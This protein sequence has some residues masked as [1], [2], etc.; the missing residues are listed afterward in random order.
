[1]LKSMCI[2]NFGGTGE[3]RVNRNNNMKKKTGLNKKEINTVNGKPYEV[4]VCMYCVC[5]LYVL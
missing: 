5:N 3:Y 2:L 1:M 4:Y